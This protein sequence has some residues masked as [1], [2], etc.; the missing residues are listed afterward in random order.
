MY[1]KFRSNTLS[2]PSVNFSQKIKSPQRKSNSYD[3]LGQAVDNWGILL[4]II[5]S[6][7]GRAYI[8]HGMIPFAIPFFVAVFIMRRDLS[9]H[10]FLALI[11]GSLTVSYENSFFIVLGVGL[12]FLLNSIVT[13]ISF[14]NP[15]KITPFQVMV[16]VSIA[17]LITNYFFA[18]SF[19]VYD[20]TI[21]LIEGGL[22]FVLLNIFYQSVP[23]ITSKKRRVALKTEEIVSFTILLAS[24]LTGTVGWS[25]EGV[26]I[27][28]VLSRFIVIL[29]A[30]IAGATVGS[31]VGVVL[32]LIL[33]LI[34]A[35][36][37]Y[38]MS[39]LAF[40]GL[41]GGLLKD[42]KK[43]GVSAGLIIGTLLLGLY[44]NEE[45]VLIY[46]A[47]ESGLACILLLLT[48]SKV[49][50]E[51]AKLIPGTQEYAN[52]QQNYL[53]KI[54]QVTSDRILKFSDA[55][56]T[57]SESFSKHLVTKEGTQRELD[58]FF[59]SVT[60][61][62]CQGCFRKQVCWIDKYQ[63]TREFMEEV[64]D[65][66]IFGEDLDSSF[67]KR[68]W[69]KRCKRPDKVKSVMDQYITYYLANQKLKNQIRE[70]RKIVAEQL[71]G[72]SKV[73][74]DF[75]NEIQREREN[76]HSL[77]EQVIDALQTLG[78]EITHTDIYSL[79][80][81][82]IDIEMNVPFCNNLSE[83][84]KII[85]PVLS[86]ILKENIIVKH[87]VCAKYPSGYCRLSFGSSQKFSALTGFAG[88]AKD[89]G[90]ISGDS[91]S[92]M[93]LGQ[94][95]YAVAI[96]DGMG[97]GLRAHDESTETL[98]L[99]KQ[100]LQLG[101]DEKVAIKSVNSILSLRTSDEIYSTLDMAMFDL[102]DASVKFL[103]IGSTPS[104]IKRGDQIIKVQANNLPMG[105]I[106]EFDVEVVSEQLRAGDLLI[107]ATD[108]IYEGP[109]NIENYD[110]WI[111]RK[112]REIKTEDPQEFADVLL[113]EVIR[114]RGSIDDDMTVVIT[115]IE[116]NM[117]KWAS[118]P[119][120][121]K[122]AN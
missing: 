99:L 107:M 91:H 78:I 100:I 42:M 68:H 29:F 44:G 12:F 32:G 110:I 119:A 16:S 62:T 86:D 37:L 48:P 79:D 121:L 2:L 95:K 105:V 40:S 20:V 25:I 111:K 64:M 11:A 84:D 71:R 30:Y 61:K 106:P 19:S 22:S 67:S 51:I 101:I 72:V 74:K 96:S 120:P 45:K 54:K 76:Y 56:S 81:G 41:L 1:T 59:S 9:L 98:Q 109:R 6:L 60:E 117:P 114:A 49:I 36:S 88:A 89:G 115:K 122:R 47:A 65:E 35:D 7:L 102:K 103:K 104:F 17:R 82:N 55:F 85:A 83:G 28:H 77:E 118:I 69:N 66:A 27:D 43:V 94:N 92:L 24:V 34:N 112:L 13:R 116:H 108:G 26:A 87:E 52:E 15:S 73:M 8:L 80:Q 90:L 75:A 5:G 53:Y 63:E 3:K 57:L 4:I 33:S 70:S 113:E 50:A 10:S 31:T 39:L 46:T 18:Q 97:N 58:Y 21:S 14:S 23:L 38:Q 93:E